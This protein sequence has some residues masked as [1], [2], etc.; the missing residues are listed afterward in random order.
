MSWLRRRSPPAHIR[1]YIGG[2]CAN[3]LGN[4]ETFGLEELYRCCEIA[5]E[6]TMSCKN[7]AWAGSLRGPMWERKRESSCGP[8]TATIML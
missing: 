6:I 4:E 8:A 2:L 1:I 3:N 5:R 7:G